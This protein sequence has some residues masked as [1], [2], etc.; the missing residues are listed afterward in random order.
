MRTPAQRGPIGNWLRDE[1]IA[2][3]WT[4]AATARAN[5]DRAGIR[6]AP[7]VYAEWESGTRL[8]SERHLEQLRAFYGSEPVGAATG[9]DAVAAAIDRQT[10]VLGALVDELRAM[11]V[12]ARTTPELL[13]SVLGDLEAGGR[14][15]QPRPGRRTGRVAE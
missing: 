8:P 2:R 13:G 3:G 15:G 6:V 12:E 10:E 9:R 1:R 4:N 11:R 7:S 14:G 5:L